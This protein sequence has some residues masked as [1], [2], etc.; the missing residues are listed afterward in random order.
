MENVQQPDAAFIA[1]IEVNDSEIV[2][3]D[4]TETVKTCGDD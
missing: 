3:S 4:N 2:G 1:S